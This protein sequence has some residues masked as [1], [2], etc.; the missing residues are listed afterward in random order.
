VSDRLF[1]R[2][3]TPLGEL[4]L[5]GD[6][7][8]LRGVYFADGRRPPLDGCRSAEA[9]FAAAREQLAEWFA[10]AR[11]SFD[12]PVEPGGTP[13]Q[14]RVWTALA[15]VP[16]GTTR[17]Y[18]DLAAELGTGPRAV[19]LANGRNPLSIVV[20]CH[21]LVGSTGA[22]TGYGGGLERKRRLLDHE[23]RRAK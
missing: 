7:H 11:T 18:G 21:R 19:G 20:P 5:V 22:L 1:C 12:L 16:Y 14:R 6:E 9:P 13:F 23:R 15:A 8:L 17:T 4:L 10:H 3:D 2:A